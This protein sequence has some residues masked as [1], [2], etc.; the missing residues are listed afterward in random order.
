MLFTFNKFW[1]TLSLITGSWI[2][3]SIWN[4]EM[5]AITLL[6]LIVANNFEDSKKIY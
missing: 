6:C 5:V 3:Y 4:F 2:F 1:K